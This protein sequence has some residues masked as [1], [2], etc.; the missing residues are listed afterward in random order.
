M[1]WGLSN[2]DVI[3]C[4]ALDRWVGLCST[5]AH[6]VKT[7]IANR[8]TTQGISALYASP[9]LVVAVFQIFVVAGV[10]AFEKFVDH[11]IPLACRQLAPIKSSP[12][13]FLA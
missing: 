10:H 13:I 7:R 1:G 12:H 5:N 9:M 3:V 4:F 6:D 11:A 2:T 8:W